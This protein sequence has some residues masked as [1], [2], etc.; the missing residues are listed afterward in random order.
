[1]E[2][3]EPSGQTKIGQ[4]DVTAPIQEDIVGL[5]ITIAHVSIK[6]K[7]FGIVSVHTDG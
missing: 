6:K 5:D 3:L 1:M 7:E 4:F 2:T